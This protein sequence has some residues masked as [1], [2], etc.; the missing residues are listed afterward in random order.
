MTAKI[1]LDVLFAAL[2]RNSVSLAEI[3]EKAGHSRSMGT[4]ITKGG[5][6]RSKTIGSIAEALGIEVTDLIA[7]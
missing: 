4:R 2:C 6:V 3:L 5:A 1:N 7:K